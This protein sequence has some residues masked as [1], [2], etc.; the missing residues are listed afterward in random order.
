MSDLPQAV[1]DR[2]ERAADRMSNAGFFDEERKYRSAAARIRAGLPLEEIKNIEQQMLLDPPPGVLHRLSAMAGLGE[3]EA[4]QSGPQPTPD[5]SINQQDAGLFT[6]QLNA[7][8]SQPNADSFNFQPN[9]NSSTDQ[10]STVPFTGQPNIDSYTGQPD[11]VSSASP[12][13]WYSPQPD[14]SPQPDASP[15]QPSPPTPQDSE[16]DQ[17]VPGWQLIDGQWV[18]VTDVV[19]GSKTNVT[20][21]DAQQDQS[22]LSP[23]QVGIG[24]VTSLQGFINWMAGNAWHDEFYEWAQIPE[25]TF[26]ILSTFGNTRP[27]L[28]SSG[29]ITAIGELKTTAAIAEEGNIAIQLAMARGLGVPYTLIVSPESHV[30]EDL[31]A[32]IKATGGGVYVFSAAKQ[33]ISTYVA[34]GTGEVLSAEAVAGVLAG[35]N[36]SAEVVPAAASAGA[37]ALSATEG[38]VVAATGEALT[39]EAGG[40]LGVEAAEV[41]AEALSLLSIL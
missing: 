22:W 10:S 3:Y 41:A 19:M 20:Y 17:L 38:P 36:A 27:D 16:S 39:A 5:S 37:S 32:A 30:V 2:L 7:S 1:A 15:G 8:T 25:N 29:L 21:D 34:G 13:G 11:T 9:A 26:K 12:N 4:P 23:M 40:A 14:I 33:T 18:Y 24:A 28:L 6:S 35:L 31:V